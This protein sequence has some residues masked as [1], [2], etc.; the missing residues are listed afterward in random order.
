MPIAVQLQMPE[1]DH[2]EA[3]EPTPGCSG[4]TR[5][6]HLNLFKIGRAHV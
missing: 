1:E 3:N 5:Q 6:L 2:D 4:M